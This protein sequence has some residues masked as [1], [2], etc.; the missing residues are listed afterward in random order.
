MKLLNITLIV[1]SNSDYEKLSLFFR[2]IMKWSRLPKEIILIQT[3][4]KKQ[5]TNKFFI[6]FCKKNNILFKNFYKPNLYPGAARNIGIQNST[7]KI[8]SFLD[9]GT[10][11]TNKWLQHGFEKINKTNSLIVWGKT[12][13]ITNSKKE[14]IIRASTYGVKPINTLPGSIIDKKIFNI[15]GI[16]LNNIRSGEDAEWIYRVNMHN[17]LTCNS[18]EIIKY[19]NLKGVS[20]TSIIKKW[21]RNY[22]FSS[23][24]SY[25]TANRDI[26]L[27]VFSFLIALLAYN[28]NPIFAEWSH[29]SPF[30]IPHITKVSMMFIFLAYFFIR[31]FILPIK[32]GHDLKFLLP[33]SVFKITLLSLCIDVTKL[34]SFICAKFYIKYY[35]NRN[36]TK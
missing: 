18:K 35:E 25:L 33:L 7:L 27:L 17:V 21:F 29:Q 15:V 19:Q 10:H 24:L 8:L 22:C 9:V 36:N 14:E 31:G 20:Y 6:N 12:Y 1:P 5:L 16:F 2:N 28:W 30:Y 23:K 32:K 26:Y 13:Y 3:N 11:A 34:I 4:K